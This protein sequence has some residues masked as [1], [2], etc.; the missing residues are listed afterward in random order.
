LDLLPPAVRP[1]A[2]LNPVA[3]I[4]AAFRA[5]LFGTA[6]DWFLLGLSAVSLLGLVAGSIWLFHHVE[7]DLAEHV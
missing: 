4:L 3:G 1:F 2:G 6:P 7:N 5:C